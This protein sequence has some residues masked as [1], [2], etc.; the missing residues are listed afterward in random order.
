MAQILVDFVRRQG[1][2]QTQGSGV[3]VGMVAARVGRALVHDTVVATIAIA[4]IAITTGIIGVT[5]DGGA[6]QK[7][8]RVAATEQKGGI[9][10]SGRIGV[11]VCGS[12]SFAIV[13]AVV[14]VVVA[15]PTT[16]CQ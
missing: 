2:Q 8:T 12:P 13:F 11:G 9:R 16:S 1:L 15:T 5:G 4:T 3:G 6:E 10:A 14:V 7:A